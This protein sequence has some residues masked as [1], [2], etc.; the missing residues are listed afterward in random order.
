MFSHV[1]Q[2]MP[3]ERIFQQISSVR[4]GETVIIPRIKI[5]GITG[6][7]TGRLLH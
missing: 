6:G 5:S 7:R 4:N 2:I 1:S 3:E